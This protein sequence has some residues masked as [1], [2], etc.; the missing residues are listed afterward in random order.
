M[1]TLIL[2]IENKIKDNFFILGSVLIDLSC[3]VAMISKGYFE[4]LKITCAKL[5]GTY[6]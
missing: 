6:V 1:Y 2:P 3:A 4:Y 5:L